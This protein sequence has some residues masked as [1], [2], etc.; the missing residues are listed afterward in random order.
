MRGL[1][2][3]RM[4]CGSCWTS[5]NEAYIYVV[6]VASYEVRKECEKYFKRQVPEGAM[7]RSAKYH[8]GRVAGNSSEGML[9]CVRGML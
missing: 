6:F 3:A 4:R 7:A 2:K 5:R 1:L 8:P 9:S